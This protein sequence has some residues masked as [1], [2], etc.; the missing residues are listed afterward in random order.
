[1]DEHGENG[2]EPLEQAMTYESARS[3]GL[4]HSSHQYGEQSGSLISNGCI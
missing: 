3:N 2:N 4:I 1:M